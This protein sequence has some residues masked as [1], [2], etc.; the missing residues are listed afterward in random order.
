MALSQSVGS[1]PKVPP[2]KSAPGKTSPKNSAKATKGRPSNS[3][4]ENVDITFSSDEDDAPAVRNPFGSQAGKAYNS[5]RIPATSGV[6]KSNPRTLTRRALIG[7]RGVSQE[8]FK[9]EKRER[10][11]DPYRDRAFTDA[12]RGPGS[13]R[14]GPTGR[15]R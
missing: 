14:S 3:E 10:Q 13:A 6:N 5:I 4:G 2:T 8:K 12:D 7:N 11:P 1:M 15:E 9:T